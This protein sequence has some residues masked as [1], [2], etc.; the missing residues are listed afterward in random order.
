MKKRV[1]ITGMG[2]V[3]PIG[4]TTQELWEGI[5]EGRNG[6]GPITHFDTTDF[7]VK[8]A[9][10]V[11][12]F[13]PLIAIEKKEIRRT[14]LYTQ[15]G[16]VAAQEAY[17]M[18]G[19][20][21]NNIKPEELAVI[22]GSGI[23]GMRT[24]ENACITLAEKGPSRVSP[25]LVP[26]M[27]ANILAGTIAIRYNAQHLCHSIV[28]ACATGAQS[29]GEAFRL[30]QQDQAVAVIAG[31]AEAPITPVGVAGFASMTALSTTNDPQRSSIP[32]DKERDGFVIG[33]GSGIFILEELEHA[34]ARGAT[35][36]GEIAGY[37]STC[38]AYHITAPE[39]SGAGA[40][41]AMQRAI[42][43][44]GIAPADI[45]YINAHGTSTPMNDLTETR[46]IKTAFGEAAYRIPISSTKSST[47][48]LLGGA[49]A[50]A[51]V[52]CLQALRHDYLPPTLH[53]E[54]PDEE[55]DLDYIPN[56]GRKQPLQYTLANSFGFGGHN[57]CLILKKY[58]EPTGSEDVSC[59]T[60]G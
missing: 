26:M 27:I 10:E 20:N 33:E 13:D 32:F 9:A 25:F 11:K 48:H 16:L 40:V 24:F 60:C 44:A 57:A 49:G 8:I 4:N 31:A 18:S 38:D 39:P 17:I 21:A 52:I 7:K 50:L 30:I 59:K 22:V 19:L 55:L 14:D 46:A 34:L 45:S 3:S 15:F 54:V 47:G 43:D 2:A 28:T 58:T 23:G 6:I 42:Q 53:Y 56:V 1:V 37:A 29:I 51:A 5:L 36:Y 41:M 35:I 12:N